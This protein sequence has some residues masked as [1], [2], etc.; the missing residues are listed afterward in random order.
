MYSHVRDNVVVPKLQEATFFSATT[1][2][3]T[4]AANDSYMTITIHFISS[5]WELNSFCLETVPLFTDHTGQNI[6]DAILDILENWNLSRDNLVA[7]T[8]DS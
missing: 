5:D 8:T 2:M 7:T 4:S 3:W 6:A 1:D